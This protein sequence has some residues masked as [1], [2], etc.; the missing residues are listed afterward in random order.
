MK[1]G[2]GPTKVKNY[3]SAF[4]AAEAPTSIEN[5]VEQLDE[6]FALAIRRRLVSDVPVCLFLS[7]GVDSSLIAAYLNR[8]GVKDTTAFTIG[9]SDVPGCNE[10][11]FARLAAKRFSLR[12]R[13]IL[14]DSKQA[15]ETLE[16]EAAVLDEPISDWV[17]VPLY[18][19][20]RAAHQEGFKVALVVRARTSSSWA[21][22][23]RS[24]A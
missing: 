2:S 17:W 7:G 4:S 1:E 12:H 10:F 22:T 24:R 21:T 3:W 8:V 18:H 20:S 11:E 16:D 13:E 6:A 5:A 9:Y 19:L 14:L 15:L 23:P